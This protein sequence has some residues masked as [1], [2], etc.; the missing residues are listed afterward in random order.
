MP[1]LSELI[2]PINDILKN[3]IKVDPADKIQRLPLYAKGKGK[4]RKC[5]PNIQKYWLPIHTTNYEAI[6]SLIVQAPVLHLPAHTG[7]FYL[8]CDPSAKHV[9][10]VL[11]QI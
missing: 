11:Y 6:K 10:S 1:K 3:C 2:K 7:L 8:E 5:S 9:G 4:G